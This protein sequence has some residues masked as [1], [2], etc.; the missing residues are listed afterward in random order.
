MAEAAAQAFF[1]SGEMDQVTGL[2]SART[3]VDLVVESKRVLA[4]CKS[5]ALLDEV[6][7]FIDRFIAY[8][9]EHCLIAHALW[10]PHAHLMEC[11]EATP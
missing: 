11:R 5:V 3:L 6:E 7:K 9:S 8:P 4:L 2:P 1:D 10:I